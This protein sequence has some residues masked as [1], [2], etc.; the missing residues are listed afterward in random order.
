MRWLFSSDHGELDAVKAGNK[1]AIKRMGRELQGAFE[2]GVAQRLEAIEALGAALDDPERRAAG[3][4]LVRWMRAQGEEAAGRVAVRVVRVALET[5]SIKTHL[6]LLLV[7]SVFEPED[8]GYTFLEG[9]LRRP[10]PHQGDRVMA[11]IGTGTGWISLALLLAS[12]V[13]RAVGFDINPVAVRIARI[14]AIINS[15]GDDLAPRYDA[16]RRLLHERF[17]ARQSDLLQAAIDAGE[18][19]DLVVGCIPQVLAPSPDLDP[20]RALR[21][22]DEGRLYDLSNYF[23]LQGVYEDQFGLG[24]LARALDQSVQVLSEGGRA[25]L[26]VAGRPGAAVIEGMFDRRGFAHQV[27]WSTRVR[28]AADTDI[29]V[30]AQLEAR[31]RRAFEFY[32][33]RHSREPVGA[34]T[35]NALREA[36]RPIWHDVRVYEASLRHERDMRPF[37]EA[38]RGLDG[39]DL[40]DQLDLSRIDGEQVGY[41]RALAQRQVADRRAPYSHEAGSALLRQRVSAYLERFYSLDE[42][43][44]SIFVGPNREE[45]LHG[46]LR[47][48]CARGDRVLVSASVAGVYEAACAKAEVEVVAANDDLEEIVELVEALEPALVLLALTPDERRNSAGLRGLLAATARR[49]IPVVLDGSDD[50]T[51]TS[52]LHRNALL[53]FLGREGRPANALILIGLIGNRVYPHLRPALLLGARGPLREA[54]V[55]FAEATYSRNDTFAEHYY[56]HLFE[57][58]LSF[59]LRRPGQ[60][61]RAAPEGASA[62]ALSQDIE[63]VLAWPAFEA[64]PPYEGDKPLIRLDYGE[65]ELPLPARLTKGLLLGFTNLGASASDRGARAAAAG[66]CRAVMGWPVEPEQLVLG[67]GVFPLLYD[68]ALALR[69]RAGRSLKVGL[70]K[71]HYGYLPPIFTLAGCEVVEIPARAD[72]GFLVRAEGLDAAEA[73]SGPLDVLFVNAPANPSGVAYGLEG[74]RE[75]ALW[76]R[77]REVTLLSDEIFSLLQ[78]DPEGP[79]QAPGLFDVLADLPEVRARLVAF[80]GLS[81]AFAAG[82]LRVGWAASADAELLDRV[83]ALRTVAPAHHACV[84]T[85]TLLRGF[86]GG[87]TGEGADEVLDYLGAMRAKLGERRARLVDLLDAHGLTPCPGPPAGLFVFCD[88]GALGGRRHPGFGELSADNAVDAIRACAGL[89]LNP[90]RWAGAPGFARLCF[91]LT[92]PAF[93][94]A[95]RRLSAFLAAL[96]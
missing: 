37:L 2:E 91:S 13:E 16:R 36:G 53:D 67:A 28:Q 59:Q 74:L 43:P 92:E 4:R 11:E 72:R 40:L 35:A 46:V 50:F 78:L 70:P 84:A 8:W 1:D 10:S 79:P 31:T 55:A 69:Q 75:I 68:V 89:Q 48:T 86:R 7:P 12:G 73:A 9:L 56:E 52:R 18:R 62:L 41:L 71:G 17:E 25:V 65:N 96:T 19:Y 63:R 76:A 47:A 87:G 49:Q 15:Y 60:R 39:D 81:K 42:G 88:L 45:A 30:L 83:R 93:E 29:G 58:I 94:V 22:G 64:P 54:L 34:A 44:E 26:N 27:I 32:V 14:N 38:V 3:L 33:D 95:L 80:S 51:I 24:L 5:A 61:A 77:D 85:E 20:V 66:F 90:G 82:G 6:D 23:V 21:E 57:E